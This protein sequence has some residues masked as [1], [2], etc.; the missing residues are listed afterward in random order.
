M[1][2]PKIEGQALLDRMVNLGNIRYLVFQKEVGK[3]GTPHFQGT[4]RFPVSRGI[5]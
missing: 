1:N 4:F 5:A 2:N 3:E